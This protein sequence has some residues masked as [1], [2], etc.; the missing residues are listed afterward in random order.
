MIMSSDL[1]RLKYKNQLD[2][3]GVTYLACI[4]TAAFTMRDYIDNVLSHY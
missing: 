1:I 3:D 4:N 2:E